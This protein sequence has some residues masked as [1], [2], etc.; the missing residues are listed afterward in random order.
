M[1]APAAP[2]AII[3]KV[4]ALTPAQWQAIDDY[5]YAHR[6]PSEVAALRALIEAGLKA[7]RKRKGR[8]DE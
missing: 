2:P 5:R 6:L 8:G 3:R 7:G 1:K 4:V